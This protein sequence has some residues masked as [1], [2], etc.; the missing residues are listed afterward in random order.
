[1]NA[2]VQ[3]LHQLEDRNYVRKAGTPYKNYWHDWSFSEM[4][5]KRQAT[6][7]D[8]YLII[9]GSSNSETD[10]FVIPYKAVKH[11]LTEGTL[12]AGREGD[13]RRRWIGTIRGMRLKISHADEE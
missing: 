12:V 6:G 11:V 7:D 4:Q 13:N 10:F 9:Y 2:V 1:M 3:R 8:F 5:R